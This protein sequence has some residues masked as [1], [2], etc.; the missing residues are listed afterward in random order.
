MITLIRGA[1]EGSRGLSSIKLR[2]RE[3]EREQNGKRKRRKKG[4][5]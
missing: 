3:R 4:R 2:K 1:E 5:V